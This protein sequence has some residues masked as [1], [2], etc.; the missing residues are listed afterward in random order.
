MTTIP[1]RNRRGIHLPLLEIAAFGMIIAAVVIFLAELSRF[2]LADRGLPFGMELAGVPV[3]GQTPEQAV[4]QVEQVYGQ[5]VVLRY[6]VTCA[7]GQASP[8]EA[9]SAA[10][11]YPLTCP[12]GE[13]VDCEALIPL[14]PVD[15]GLR[16]NSEA[17]L[18]AGRG[19]TDSGSFWSRFWNYLWRKPSREISVDLVLDYSQNQLRVKLEELAARFDSPPQPAQPVLADLSFRPGTPGYTLDV[20]AS[21]IEVDEALR[22]P[23]NRN[24]ELVVEQGD[25][26]APDLDTL[27][28]LVVSYLTQPELR[29]LI[30][31]RLGTTDLDAVASVFVIDL[32]TGEE[33]N[34][35]VNFGRP[36]PI[37]YDYDISYAAT[38][39]MKIPIMV[40]MFRY[41][42][43][44]PSVEERKLLDETMTLSGNFSANLMLAEVGDGSP[45]RGVET[46]TESMSYLG[47]TN[48]FIAAEYD[49]EDPPPYIATE[50]RECARLGQCIDTRADPYMQVTTRDIAGLLN[51]IHQC[52]ETGGGG[53][54]VAYPGEFTQ[55]ECQ[56]MMDLMNRNEEGVLILAGVPEGTPVA[57]KHGWISDT[58]A[59]AGIVQSPGG[60]YVL[61][62]FIWVD[63]DWLEFQISLPLMQAISEATF[64]YFNPDLVGEPRIGWISQ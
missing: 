10:L 15:I 48:T 17:M 13:T 52:A 53:L 20:D 18:S 12:E 34:L 4:A 5:Q 57:H 42:G 23:V 37:Y 7:E 47:L 3:G 16:V 32:E 24:A 38:S 27:G 61:V 40:E 41:I 25:A 60:D 56:T 26:P 2:S 44:T 62:T 6:P 55:T 54:M 8:C 22:R 28:Q 36:E 51:M 63:V 64:N 21:L 59:D 43:W 35:N 33:L 14:E 45:T 9:E 1:S 19:Q 49:E 50:A 29:D 58:I 11:Q 31:R 46:V 30:T 39:V